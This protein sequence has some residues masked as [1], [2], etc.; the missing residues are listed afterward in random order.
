[1]ELKG[2]NNN[3]RPQRRQLKIK[4]LKCGNQRNPIEN[5]HIDQSR[6]EEEKYIN[7]INMPYYESM[8]EAEKM[9]E[10]GEQII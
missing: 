10:R 4:L 7:I 5:Y 9:W 6:L 3:W 8:K 2:I 1:M